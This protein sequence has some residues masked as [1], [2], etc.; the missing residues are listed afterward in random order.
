LLSTLD[1]RLLTATFGN[2]APR[3]NLTH[4]FSKAVLK[5]V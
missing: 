2:Y 4:M 1:C 5:A 3:Q